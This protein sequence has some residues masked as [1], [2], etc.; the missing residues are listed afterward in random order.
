M[1]IT[2]PVTPVVPAAVK[3]YGHKDHYLKNVQVYRKEACGTVLRETPWEP[4]KTSHAYNGFVQGVVRA[5]NQHH[6]L[7][8]RPDDV[9]LAIAIQFGLFVN[10]NAEELRHRFVAHDGKKELVVRQVATLNTAD[11]GSLLAKDMVE[12]LKK[13]VTDEELCA[14]ILPAFSTTTDNDRVVGSVVLMAS[15]KA[16]FD[17]KMELCCG[18]PEVTLLGTPEEWDA[19]HRR[20]DK[21]RSY[22]KECSEWADMLEKITENL[23]RSSRGDI[24]ADFWQRV[25]HYTPTGS[26]PTYLSGWISVFCAFDGQGKWH[27]GQKS[28]QI[29]TGD[30]IN[31]LDYPVVNISD[32]PPGFLTTDVTIDDNGQ[33]HKAVLF[34]GHTVFEAVEQ[35]TVAPKLTWALVLKDGVRPVDDS[36]SDE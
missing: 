29:W 24:P 32:M 20:V 9:W 11:Y 12:Q 1:T 5:Y 23:A 15:M 13:A 2:F 6:K 25:C 10:A 19:V 16:Y 18:I 3:P 28:V 17:Y 35:D 34:A 30:V 7:I 8:L 22:G 26:G 21:L 36:D 31:D 33:E 27:G 4:L 14:W